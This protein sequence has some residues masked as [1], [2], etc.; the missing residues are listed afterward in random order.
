MYSRLNK[1][2]EG[3]KKS[4][5]LGVSVLKI[6]DIAIF[7]LNIQS[8][9]CVYV[10][11]HMRIYVCGQHEKRR[12]SPLCLPLPL[13]PQSFASLVF[14]VLPAAVPP[15]L[16]DPLSVPRPQLPLAQHP[17]SLGW[18]RSSGYLGNHCR[19][20]TCNWPGRGLTLGWWADFLG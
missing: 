15:F 10:C 4:Y 1:Q 17:S 16:S 11:V 18:H 7:A 8:L 6:V 2:I 14:T 9:K 13:F 19:A 5:R 3:V 12:N 20:N